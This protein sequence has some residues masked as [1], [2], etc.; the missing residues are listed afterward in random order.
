MVEDN[1]LIARFMGVETF[2][3]HW[4]GN[5]SRVYRASDLPQYQPFNSGN[6]MPSLLRYHRS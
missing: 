5:S 2:I 1:E 3:S 4:K 6:I